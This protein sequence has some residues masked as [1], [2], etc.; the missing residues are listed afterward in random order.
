MGEAHGMTLEQSIFCSNLK[1]KAHLESL[2]V[3]TI[4]GEHP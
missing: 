1:Q 2:M 3:P 4:F